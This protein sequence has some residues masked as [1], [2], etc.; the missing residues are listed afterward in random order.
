MSKWYSLHIKN[1]ILLWFFIVAILPLLFISTLYFYNL[2]SDFEESTKKYLTQV[3]NE[4]VESTNNYVESLQYQVETLSMLPKTREYLHEYESAFKENKRNNTPI[5]NPFFEQMLEKSG[6]YDMFLIDLDGNIL[7]SVKHE[8]DLYENL[9]N[10]PLN[11]SG[12]AWAFKK[13]KFLLDT[14]IATFSYYTPSKR[15]ASF[16]STPIFKEKK[17][18]GVLAIQISEEKLFSMILNYDG[19]GETGEIV[20]GYLDK[21]KNILAAI[22]LRF[23]HDAFSNDF[24]LQANNALQRTVPVANAILGNFGAGTA[25]DYRNVPIIAAWKYMPSLRWGMV[26]KMDYAEIMQP[27]YKRVLINMLILFFVILF[28]TI[29]IIVV[30]KHIIDPIEILISRVRNLSQGKNEIVSH[31]EIDLDNEIGTLAKS[32]NVM[33]KSL[34]DSQEVIRNY[35]TELEQ[36]VE[37]RTQELQM[38]KNELE[39]INIKM[40]KHLGVVDKYVITSATD[41]DGVITDVSEA[42][43]RISGYTKPELIGKKH[44]ILKHPDFDNSV[45][46]NLWKTITTGNN[47]YGEIKNQK[48]DGSFYWVDVIVTPTLDKNGTIDG[49]SSIRQ[50]IT[51]KKRVEELSVTDQLTK[52]YNRL[53]LENSFKK[54]V[55]RAKRYSTLFSV[56]LLDID[57]FKLVND[58]YGHDIGDTVLVEMVTILKQNIRITD[59]LGR[60]GG[61]EFLII[62]PETNA[63]QAKLLAEKLREEIAN[64]FFRV[65]G[66][67]TCSFGVSEFNLQDEDSKEVVKRA[68]N[69]LYEAKKSGRN[70]VVVSKE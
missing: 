2:Q 24:V 37:S 17:L 22:P 42:L 57:H 48:K 4:K 14:E 1:E 53:H 18:I 11:E 21:D 29:A 45:Y 47:W 15:K 52:I 27:V 10:G 38:S 49:F 44:S 43:C 32:F 3:L 65:V 64:H 67:K 5:S 12:L 41:K 50:D 66:E 6:Y 55:N 7:Y 62:L 39:E 16:I 28:I 9:L 63:P 70:R 33:S 26:V 35:A 60:W 68:D 25:Q 54:E 61:E 46:D 51:D 69:A 59:I 30:T 58:T 34:H 40:Q 8:S 13:S 56:I 23:K 36:K 20:A 19:L 31:E